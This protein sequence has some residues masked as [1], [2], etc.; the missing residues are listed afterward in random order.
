MICILILSTCLWRVSQAEDP[1]SL[2]HLLLDN[3]LVNALKGKPESQVIIYRH[4]RIK[5]VTLENHGYTAFTGP[6]FVCPDPVDQKVTLT[7]VFKSCNATPVAV[8]SA[9]MAKEMNADDELAGQLVVWTSLASTVT[10]FIYVTMHRKAPI[11]EQ[12]ASS[13]ACQ[14]RFPSTALTQPK[15]QTFRPEQSMQKVYRQT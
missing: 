7:D 4:M 8:A 15:I 13:S 6:L 14:R 11:S 10:I 3:I 9:I 1:C 2:L 12:Q 5:S